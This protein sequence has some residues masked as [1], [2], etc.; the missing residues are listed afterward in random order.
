MRGNDVYPAK[1]LCNFPGAADCKPTLSVKSD[2]TKSG[3]FAGV[4]ST[5]FDLLSKNELQSLTEKTVTIPK[6]NV[7]ARAMS[8][9]G[10]TWIDFLIKNGFVEHKSYLEDF[11]AEDIR[12]EY[13]NLQPNGHLLPPSFLPDSLEKVLQE[14]IEG[15]IANETVEYI[16]PLFFS[17]I[18]LGSKYSSALTDENFKKLAFC[19]MYAPH[20]DVR[21]AFQKCLD[22]GKPCR[23]HKDDFDKEFWNWLQDR[24]HSGV[25]ME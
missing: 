13:R 15:H 16:K 7:I 19:L 21:S 17:R 3:I 11:I 8:K 25:P 10:K 23:L 24:P 20:N 6:I 2:D 4:G 1:V 14:S 22:H 12:C 5:C 18:I 9:L